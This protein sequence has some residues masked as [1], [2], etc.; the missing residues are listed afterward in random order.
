MGKESIIH[1]IA[2]LIA[3]NA[4][5]LLC[6]S[7]VPAQPRTI[8]DFFGEFTDDWVRNHPTLATRIRYFTGEEQDRLE[9]QLTPVTSEWRKGRTNR[10]KHGLAELRKF[11]RSRMTDIQRVSTE[12][13][14]WQLDSVVREEQYSDYLPQNQLSAIFNFVTHLTVVHPLQTE[15]DAEN[16]VAALGQVG[17]RVDELL[18]ETRRIAGNGIIP[19]KFIL[20]ATIRQMQTFIDPAPAQ[21]PFVSALV[22]KMAAVKSMSDA[23]R[24]ELRDAAAKIVGEQVYPAWRRAIDLLQSQIKT[25][26]DDAGLWRLKGGAEAYAFLLRYSTTTNLTPS[27]IHDIGLKRVSEIEKQVDALLK[28]LGRTEGSL[29]D[30]IAKLQEDLRYPNPASE[31]SRELIMRDIETILKDAEK[32]AAALFDKMPKARIVAQ[33]AARYQE[34]ND[35]PS[36]IRAASD[37]SRPGIFLYPRSLRNMTKFDLRTTVYHETVPG[38]YFQYELQ[39][40]NKDLPRFR[41]T[42][43]RSDAFQEGWALYAERLVAESGWYGDDTEGLLGQIYR[44]LYRA[45]RLVVDT[46]IHAYHW[47][48]QQAIDYGIDASEVE[49]YVAGPGQ[50]CAYMIGELKFLELR[51]KAQKALGDKFSIK[52]FHN[53]ALE[54]GAV[55]LE[56]FERQVDTYTR[57]AAAG[58]ALK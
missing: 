47:T 22:Q 18:G 40:E 32:R 16:Y 27:Q 31:E 10:A 29:N 7:I 12:L 42:L 34:V 39:A 23:R 6:L 49:R 26:T 53:L 36:Y 44:E 28:R 5:L 57:R 20:Q 38:Y 33:P 58:S 37:G 56:I 11:N 30:R 21:N 9:R 2:R 17:I 41:Q 15:R 50:A 13:L 35:S 55:P 45:R 54:T 48:R 51:D 46:G 4:A 3:A 19:P 25:A 43:F 1:R 52:Q 24:A 8:D 14:E